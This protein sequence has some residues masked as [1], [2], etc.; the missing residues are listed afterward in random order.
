MPSRRSGWS[1]TLKTRI[2]AWSLMVFLRVSTVAGCRRR[3]SPDDGHVRRRLPARSSTSVPAAARLRTLNAGA[4]ALGAL[5][6][7]RKP[8]VA[9]ACPT[10][11][12]PR[13]DAAAVVAHEHPQIA[14]AVLDL[15]LDAL[16]A[17]V[18]ERVDQR[19][20][21]DPIDLV[22]DERCSGRGWPSTIT[23]SRRCSPTASSCWNPGERLLEIVAARCSTSAAR[24]RRCGPRR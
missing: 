14:R 13:I 15:D 17:R 8:P 16:A 5:A 22:A 3:T 9:V 2:L 23:R 12:R 1:S 10:A 19:L 18:P 6:H 11:A 4:D 20:A 24:A 7:A 21:A